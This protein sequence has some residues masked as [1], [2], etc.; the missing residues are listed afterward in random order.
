MWAWKDARVVLQHVT[1]QIELNASMA[2]SPDGR[3]V[4][5]TK[6]GAVYMGAIAGR[7]GGHTGS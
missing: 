3:V 1:N 6:E 4:F 2:V 5:G 7:A